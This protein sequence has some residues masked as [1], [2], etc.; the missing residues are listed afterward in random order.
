MKK[1][2]KEK[3]KNKEEDKEEEKRECI[4]TW[5]YYSVVQSEII[6]VFGILEKLLW[7]LLVSYSNI[8]FPQMTVRIGNLYLRHL[9]FWC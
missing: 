2:E 4:F 1:K 5:I 9:L 8:P 3:K 7:D 6:K